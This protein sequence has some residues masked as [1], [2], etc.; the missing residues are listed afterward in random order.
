ME[1]IVQIGQ[2]EEFH[3]HVE[4]RGKARTKKYKKERDV[5]NINDENGRK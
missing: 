2:R 4:V 1:N 5:L 3:C